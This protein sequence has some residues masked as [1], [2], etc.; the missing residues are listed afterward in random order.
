MQQQ[1]QHREARSQQYALTHGQNQRAL[2]N[3]T[4]GTD[5]NESMQEHRASCASGD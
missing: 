3:T 2:I 1:N 5:Q 4:L